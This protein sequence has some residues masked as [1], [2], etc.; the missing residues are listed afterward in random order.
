[1]TAGVAAATDVSALSQ[2]S[3][4]LLFVDALE[5]A[6]EELDRLVGLAHLI[7]HHTNLVEVQDPIE[8]VIAAIERAR[9]ELVGLIS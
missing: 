2:W 1:M 4:Q 8:D 7:V 6:Q 3:A 9:L 5:T